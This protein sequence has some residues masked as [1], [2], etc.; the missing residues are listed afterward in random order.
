[1]IYDCF[2]FFNEL[3]LLELRLQTLN[4]VVDKFVL[5]EASKTHSN[6]DKELYYQNNQARFHQYAD[7]IIHIIVNEF[8]EYINSWTFEKHQRNCI[9]QGL[10]NCKP[11]D[12]ILISDVD[13]I[14]NPITIQKFKDKQGIKTL[15]QR[16][17]Y[18]YLNN[19]DLHSPLWA[20][21]PTKMLSFKELNELGNSP[22]KVR[23][24]NGKIIHNGGWH[25]SYLGGTSK[26]SEKIKAFAHQEYNRKEYNDIKIINERV[27]SGKDI[28]LR[29]RGKRYASIKIDKSFPLYLQKNQEHFKEYIS[30]GN[31][32]L[33]DYIILL[34][35]IIIQNIKIYCKYALKKYYHPTKL[36]DYE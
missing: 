36:K 8:P 20:D 12:I 6:K 25:F 11:E 9:M 15:K 23:F 19:I 32:T 3:D 14:P 34:K 24:Y 13:E 30:P 28:F 21:T 27:K 10:N 7:K 31:I 35:N 22:Q 18:Y 1:M 17:F 33:V 5:V 26:I 16:M 29:S 4:N 2:T